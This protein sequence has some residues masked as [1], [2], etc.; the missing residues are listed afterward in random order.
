M[1]TPTNGQHAPNTT[2][3]EKHEVPGSPFFY[4]KT[5]KG[6][7]L[8]LGMHRLSPILKTKTQLTNWMKKHQWDLVMQLAI[9][10]VKKTQE[11]ESLPNNTPGDDKLIQLLKTKTN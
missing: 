7:F 2:I 6:Y 9:I 5:E 4:I 3:L 11:F 1:D 8:V 10:T